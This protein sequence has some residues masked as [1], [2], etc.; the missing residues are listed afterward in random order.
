MR[1]LSE[2]VKYLEFLLRHTQTAEPISCLHGFFIR[3]LAWS[4]R[5][6]YTLS[7]LSS[8]V[9]CAIADRKGSFIYNFAFRRVWVMH[10]AVLGYPDL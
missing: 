10:P 7:K 4:I 1:L 2:S 8:D 6:L 9:M 3:T 5:V